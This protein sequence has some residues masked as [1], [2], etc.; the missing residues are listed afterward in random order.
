MNIRKIIRETL[1]KSL[2]KQE[3]E[4]EFDKDI[5][6]LKNFSLNKKENKE[7]KAIWVFDHK[8]K[9]YTLRF[10]IQNDKKNNLWSAKIFVYWKITTRDFTN[11][12]GKDF[13]ISFG[14]FQSYD[15]MI[16]ELNRK[17][18]NNPIIS[19]ENYTDDDNTQFD[20]DLT[21]MFRLLLKNVDKL[22]IVRDEHFN[23]LKKIYKKI[24]LINSEEE[25]KKYIY[26]LCPTKE[27]KQTT[28]LVLQKIYKLDFYLKKE[29]LD[30]LF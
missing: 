11:A 29:Q 26:D 7:N 8:E 16:V 4:K 6:Y 9:D 2:N 3:T 21:E 5:V 19:L 25:L 30:D 1:E 24:K 12:K 10:Y 28:L 17:L 15:E 18:A 27:D 14:P 23:D 22:K 20:K 13:E